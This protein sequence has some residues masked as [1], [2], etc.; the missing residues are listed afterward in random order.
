MNRDKT[1][2]IISIGNE[3]LENFKRREL[4]TEFEEEFGEQF[5]GQNAQTI[6]E[7]L[8]EAC[9]T[10]DQTIGQKRIKMLRLILE[11][12]FYYSKDDIENILNLPIDN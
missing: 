11:E 6:K 10:K 9:L 12:L 7:K 1:A 2:E 5:A 3:T 8:K 4:L